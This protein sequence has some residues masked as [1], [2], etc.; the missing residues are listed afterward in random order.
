LI[1]AEARRLG[2]AFSGYL[3]QKPNIFVEKKKGVPC[4]RNALFAWMLR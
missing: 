2:N 1:A 4:Y 3:Q